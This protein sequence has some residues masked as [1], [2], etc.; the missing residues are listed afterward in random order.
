M[1]LGMETASEVTLLSLSASTAAGGHL[2]V[3][4]ILS[5]PLLFAAGMSTFDT[6]DSLI[7]TRLYSW[8]Y[9]D[10]VRTLFFNI[11]TTA[12]TVGI[13]FFIALVYIS[14]VLSEQAGWTVLEGFGGISDHFEVFG[15][16]IAVVF[17][18]TWVGALLLWRRRPAPTAPSAPSALPALP[19]PPG[20]APPS[21]ILPRP[22]VAPPTTTAR[23]RA[24]APT[25]DDD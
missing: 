3:L 23:V 12:M 17:T 8:S 25:R 6:A 16:G 4:G 22:V 20:S 21:P 7:M 9:R 5:L 10:P 19:A 13:A 14:Q 11:A 1:G 18:V 24:P 15:Y 2:P